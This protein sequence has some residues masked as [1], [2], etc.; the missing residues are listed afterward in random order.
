MNK[1]DPNMP[2]VLFERRLPFNNGR[3][4]LTGDY[5]Q[6]HVGI[7]I[8]G[9]VGNTLITDFQPAFNTCTSNELSNNPFCFNSRYFL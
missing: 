8:G 3:L 1:T 7:G 4:L 2:C 6:Y 5:A 9:T